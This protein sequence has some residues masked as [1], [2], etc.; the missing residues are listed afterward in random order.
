MFFELHTFNVLAWISGEM[1]NIIYITFFNF[2]FF[3]FVSIDTTMDFQ[4]FAKVKNNSIQWQREQ[5]GSGNTNHWQLDVTVLDNNNFHVTRTSSTQRFF[6]NASEVFQVFLNSADYL[7][8]IS[9]VLW[10]LTQPATNR[11]A[12]DSHPCLLAV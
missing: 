4:L 6:N 5:M 11:G 7:Q 12:F 8:Y 10:Q 3:C 9:S 1:L 2:H